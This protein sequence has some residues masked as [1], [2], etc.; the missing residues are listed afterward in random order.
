MDTQTSN[1]SKAGRS[2]EESSF[3]ILRDNLIEGLRILILR[4]WMFFIPFCIV[5]CIATIFS[6]RIPR[7]YTSTTVIERRDHPVL[8]NLKQTA[9]TGGF[10]RF[11]RPTLAR[12]LT[13]RDAM[14][15][16]VDRIGLV[17]P[18]ERNPDGTLTEEGQKHAAAIG[19]QYAG[20]IRVSL[21]QKDE[22][23]DQIQISYTGTEPGVPQRLV[24][25][26]K[27]TYIKQTR[28]RL[29]EMLEDVMGYFEG[30]ADKERERASVIEEDLLSFQA[31]HLGVDPTDP[32]SLKSR[33]LSLEKDRESLQDQ[34][35]SDQRE[36]RSRERLLAKYRQVSRPIVPANRPM[37]IAVPKMTKSP[38]AER[39]EQQIRELQAEIRE[40]QMVRRMTDLHPDIVERRERIALLREQLKDQYLTDARGMPANTGVALDEAAATS[41]VD[42]AVGWEAELAAIE[43]EIEDRAGRIAAAQER[44]DELEAQVDRL[45]ALETNVFQYRR[46]H[47]LKSEQLDQARIDYRTN[48]ARVREIGNILN[49]DESER[50]MSFTVLTPPTPSNRPA[51]PRSRTVL[52]LSLLAGLAV[53][54]IAV[55]LRELFDQTYRTTRQVTRSLGVAILETVDEIVTTTDRAR[56]FRRRVILAPALVLIMIGSVT[57]CCAAAYLSIEQPVAYK[58]MMEKPAKWWNRITGDAQVA[59]RAELHEAE[60]ADLASAKTTGS[61][62]G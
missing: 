23:F 21:R 18:S 44:M 57:F 62:G 60:P 14:I 45:R 43:L 25:A 61:V 24:D 16:V 51:S 12:D 13:S 11:F 56:Q 40:F 20:G 9:A 6:H 35:E 39:V 1:E 29:T 5:T 15:E 46:D 59:I 48:M 2:V 31:K 53:G 47:Q 49:A 27:D 32:E 10:A 50:G 38:E 17:D 8:M 41:A 3:A 42:Q 54:A 33:I 37:T 22:H 34:I 58:K 7:T 55:L 36:T 26:V 28:S 52:I 30:I 19:A 4:R